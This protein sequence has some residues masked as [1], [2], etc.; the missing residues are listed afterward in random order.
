MGTVTLL[1][2][3]IASLRFS[4]SIVTFVVLRKVGTLVLT[5]RLAK[6]KQ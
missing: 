2:L 6:A 1:S 3:L 5:A 4:V